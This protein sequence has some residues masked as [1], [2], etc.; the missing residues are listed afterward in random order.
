MAFGE[1]PMNLK[2]SRIKDMHDKLSKVVDTIGCTERI[3]NYT[4]KISKIK[5]KDAKEVEYYGKG[6][7][8]ILPE[9]AMDIIRE[10]R[11]LCHCVGHAGYFESMAAGGCRILFL[12]KITLRVITGRLEITGCLKKWRSCSVFR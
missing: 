11:I 8:I 2:P 6:Y 4:E 3:K 1:A 7:A 5:R 9:D 12:R 10:G